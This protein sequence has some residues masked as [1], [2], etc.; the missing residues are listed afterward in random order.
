MLLGPLVRCAALALTALFCAA[1]PAP[2]Q[3]SGLKGVIDDGLAELARRQAPDGS[4]GDLV[5]TADAVLAFAESPRR[6]GEGDGPFVR[7]ALEWLTAQVGADGAPPALGADGAKCDVQQQL[8]YAGWLDDALARSKKPEAAA[9]RERLARWRAAAK[10]SAGEAKLPEDEFTRTFTFAVEPTKLEQALA[11]MTQELFSAPVRP[12]EHRRW[13]RVTPSVL[14]DLATRAPDLRLSTTAGEPAHWSDLLGQ[15]VLRATHA[16]AGFEELAPRD[17]AAALRALTICVEH[18]PKGSAGASGGGAPPAPKGTP[19][20]VGSD[21]KASWREAA[22]SALAYLDA[23][24][25][26]GKFG[27]MGREDGGITALALASVL[28]TSKRLGQA[29]PKWADAGLDYLVSLQKENGSIHSGGLA[30]YTT[31]AALMALAEGGRPGDRAALERGALFLKVVQRDEGE[32]YDRAQDWGYGG[33]GYGNELRPDLSNTQFG[34]EGMKAAGVPADDAAMQR[35]ILFLQRCQN[36]IE[37]NPVAIERTDGRVVV[38]GNDGG[39]GYHPGESKAGLVDNGD[40]TFTTRSYGSMTYALLK[41]YL[42]AGLPRDDARVQAALGWIAK[43]WT[44]EVN[45]G[46]DPASAQG[47]EYQ[48]LF[49][50]WFT[51]AK[52]LDASGLEV[53]KTPDGKEHRWRDELLTKLLS[54]SFQEGFWTNGKSSRWMEEFPVLATSYALAAMD[55]CLGPD[56]P[57]GR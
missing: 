42:F 25:K 43:N 5:A 8:A 38:A 49:Y 6:Y 30:V 1:S 22:T 3:G 37:A 35:A 19:R 50:Y 16:P 18:A 55:H 17:L 33:I 39:A 56:A 21:L 40:G 24:Q 10:G 32:G 26:D 23:Q 15:M 7:K 13:L 41:C 20:A 36:S 27:F 14:R 57:G 48:G 53:L 44:V 12:E 46:F 28:R 45:P 51:M 31:S 29:P 54:I 34:L 47:A 2:A 52:A 9:A 11:P 4:Y